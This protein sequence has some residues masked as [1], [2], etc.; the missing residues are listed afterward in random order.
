MNKRIANF[1][2]VGGQNSPFS[3]GSS[4]LFRG[5]PSGYSGYG[6]NNFSGDVSLDTLMS[7]SNKPNILGFERPFENLL[8][9][10][11]ENVEEDSIPYLLDF[12]ERMSLKKKKKIRAK[13]AYLKSLRDKEEPEKDK[14]TSVLESKIKTV[15]DLLENMRRNQNIDFIKNAAMKLPVNLDDF[16][17]DT[18]L[19]KQHV[20]EPNS[21]YRRRN[22]P[23]TVDDYLPSVDEH[24]DESNSLS[25]PGN[26][27][28][29]PFTGIVPQYNPV[30]GLN[31]YIE[32]INNPTF[33]DKHNMENDT[34]LINTPDPG[35]NIDYSVSGSLANDGSPVTPRSKNNNQTLEQK[36]EQLKKNN[37]DIKRLFMPGGLD[38]D[39]KTRGNWN[40]NRTETPYQDDTLGTVEN[41]QAIGEFT[42]NNP[43]NS[44]LGGR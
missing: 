37:L 4:P 12:D 23:G 1:G 39:K 38:W 36:L 10:F 19:N 44:V 11:H 18:K 21:L 34:L 32:Q 40:N 30:D 35:A 3:P 24:V 43:Y 22:S 9:T 17:L 25:I 41:T 16:N 8:E 28:T 13:E 27:F 20:N 15:E 33:P 14:R 6:I 26:Q 31:K 2:G 42:S 7:R 29:E 5:G